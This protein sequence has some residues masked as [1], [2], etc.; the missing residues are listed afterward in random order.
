MQFLAFLGENIIIFMFALLAFSLVFRFISYKST[1]LD[2]IYYTTFTKEIGKVLL[3][4]ETD[5]NLTIPKNDFLTKLLDEVGNELPHRS[6]RFRRPEKKLKFGMSEKTESDD[7]DLGGD[8]QSGTLRREDT[9][10]RKKM[11]LS[12]YESKHALI[13]NMLNEKSVFESNFPPNYMELTH[14]VL[15]RDK[16]WVKL[17]G[18]IPIEGLSR[19]IDIL[20]GIFVILGILGTFIGIS[21]ALPA[22][23][24]INFENLSDSSNILNAFV[25]SVTLSMSTSIIG[26][27]CSLAMTLLNTLYPITGVRRKIHKEMV[28]C[29]ERI[30][31]SIHGGET[32]EQQLTHVLPEIRDYVKAILDMADLGTIASN[33]KSG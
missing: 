11:S 32:V 31:Y 13:S 10:I 28:N 27:V 16:N 4:Y 9:E 14:R 6:L 17:F 26:I 24:S 30:W 19:F 18:I 1:R 5:D 20:P 22:I 21:L 23:A 29:M 25:N 8:R 3:A 2:N 7:R 15:D 12:E 33:K